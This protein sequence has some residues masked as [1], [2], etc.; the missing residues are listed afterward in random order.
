M[1]KEQKLGKT[2][3]VLGAGASA[4]FGLPLGAQL[5]DQA[6]SLLTDLAS[7]WMRESRESHFWDYNRA[8]SFVQS[9]DRFKFLLDFL[10]IENDGQKTISIEHVQNF[11]TLMDSAPVYSLDTLALEFPEHTE[12]IRLL[13]SFLISDAVRQNIEVDNRGKVNW[14]FNRRLIGPGKKLQANWIHLFCSM[15]RNEIATQR[16]SEIG[17]ISFNYDR[18]FENIGKQIWTMPTRNLGNFDSIFKISYPHGKI[19]WDVDDQLR[20]NFKIEKSEIVF[21]HNKPE[22]YENDGAADMVENADRLIFLGFHFSPENIATLRLDQCVQ[23]EIVYQ[24]F[25]GNRGLDRRVAE[26]P[27]RDIRRFEGSISDAIL[28]GELGALPS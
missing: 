22:G 27:F 3:L 20:S 19:S 21:A 28:Q 4:D 7:G 25:D 26:L 24:N 17:V 15:V 8:V 5:Y 2:V 12:L 11:L 1:S 14:R 23:Q 16:A 10:H 13:T 9:E 6:V 18:L